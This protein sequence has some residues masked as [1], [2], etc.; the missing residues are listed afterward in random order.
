MDNAV[1]I[2]RFFRYKLN[3]THLAVIHVNNGYGNAFADDLKFA[4][5]VHAPDL[6]IE[7][8]ELSEHP[9]PQLIT[10]VVHVIKES[11]LSYIFAALLDNVIDDV[12][13]EAYRQGVAGNGI[14]NW[15]FSNTFADI[16]DRYF[17][18]DS[19]LH[20]AYRGVGRM[21]VSGGHQGMASFDTFACNLRTLRSSPPDLDYLSSLLPQKEYTNTY[22]FGEARDF[23]KAPY[24]YD[25]DFLT[26]VP[27]MADRT[28]PAYEAAI[29]LG[30]AACEVVNQGLP[31]TGEVH[32]EEFKRTTFKGVEAEVKFLNE[33]G[34]R[35]PNTTLFAVENEVEE[36]IEVTS[37][38]TTATMIKFRAVVSDI[39]DHG[40]WEHLEDYVFNDGTTAIQP[41]LVP[42][43]D[44][45]HHYIHTPLKIIAGLMFLFIMSLACRF[46][47][48]TETNKKQ[49]VVRA[50]QPLFLRVIC[51]G[52][53]IF[54][55]AI[56]PLNI[57]DRIASVDG[58]TIACNFYYW[59][60]HGRA[61]FLELL[62]SRQWPHLSIF[63]FSSF[64]WDS[65][66]CFRV[67]LRRFIELIRS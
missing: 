8:H 40:T 30:L 21:E 39:Y 57:D 15:F 46:L 52:V 18:K 55:S 61:S 14:H 7:E 25:D 4:A 1:P 31:L 38:G 58:C 20:H 51:I 32:F 3:A 66:L 53:M 65:A 13:E 16:G 48:W 59:V 43:E 54:A 28:S 41:D 49:R 5:Q 62:F 19:P 2:V 26:P 44:V 45:V 64:S 12:M 10:D 27:K 63:I 6:V 50:S 36:E 23:S 60:S 37:N 9:N 17:E 56:V 67:C 24:I 47:Y 22:D 42:P 29:A 11:K 33:S 34:T 35:D